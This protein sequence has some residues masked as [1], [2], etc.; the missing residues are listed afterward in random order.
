MACGH[1][2]KEQ[3]MK[4]YVVMQIEEHPLTL[5]DVLAVFAEKRIAELFIDE[6][7]KNRTRPLA[8]YNS[9]IIEEFDLISAGKTGE[10]HNA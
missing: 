9:I 3:A 5:V 6:L 10:Q 1:S 7:E 4:V 2:S 8:K